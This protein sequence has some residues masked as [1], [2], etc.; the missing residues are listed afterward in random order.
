MIQ[1]L[2]GMRDLLPEERRRFRWLETQALE[3]ASRYGFE[4]I[5]TPVLESAAVFSR[6]LGDATD[7]VTKQMYAFKD[8]GGDDVVMRPEGTAG[9][10]RAFI[11]EGLAQRLPLKLFYSGPMF[12]YE[13][14]QKGRFRQFYQMGVEILGV[15][16]PR[17]DAELIAL[18]WHVLRAIGV[19]DRVKLQINT[20]G[21][22]ASRAAYRGALVDF[23]RGRTAELSAE[24]VER[25]EKNPLRI[26]DSKDPGD[27]K[28]VSE[29]PQ[30]GAY[31]NDESRAFFDKTLA[32]LDDLGVPFERDPL[33]V[34]GLDYYCHAV[35]E[36]TTEALGAQNAV[37]SGGRYDGLIESLGGKRTPGVGWA[38]GI[39]RLAELIAE[40][41]LARRPVAIIPTDDATERA[42]WQIAQSL[43][44][45][46]I[47]VDLAFSGNVGK[48]FKRADQARAYA[49]VILG[50][51]E[52]ARGAAAVK[53]L[54]SG[55]QTETPIS[56]LAARL[57]ALAP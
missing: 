3:I 34:R 36:F 53:R 30:F 5:E 43:R 28:V 1:A 2:R 49:A 50:A 13:R 12:R 33:L 56:E 32:G 47:A 27:R 25:L 24:S 44:E 29:G 54:D 48:R 11:S 19:S 16:K 4:E 23:L 21:D 22:G 39:D 20:V 7:I 10:A 51:E 57:K 46:G 37:L 14:P 55:D 15:E 31:L 45:Q 38:A 35:F 52:W 42:A 18:G 17:A 8:R 26:L 40:P 6:T 9:V 41:P